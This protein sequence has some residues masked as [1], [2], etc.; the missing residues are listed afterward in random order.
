M[1]PGGHDDRSEDWDTKGFYDMDD[2][3]VKAEADFY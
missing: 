2:P 1:I 3:K